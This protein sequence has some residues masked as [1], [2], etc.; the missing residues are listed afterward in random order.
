MTR[1]DFSDAFDE[2]K[3]FQFEGVPLCDHLLV[4]ALRHAGANFDT[5]PPFRG[6]EADA[7]TE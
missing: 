6:G 1:E 5:P 2:V 3:A 7:S 4:D